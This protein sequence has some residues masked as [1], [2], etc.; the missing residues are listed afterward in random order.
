ME[1]LLNESDVLDQ[2]DTSLFEDLSRRLN[3]VAPEFDIQTISKDD[4]EQ[5]L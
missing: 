4:V 2:M 1:Q 3:F 5:E